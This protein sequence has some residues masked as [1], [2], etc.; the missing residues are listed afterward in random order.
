[1]AMVLCVG[2]DDVLMT[3][4]KMILER[5]GHT[6]ISVTDQDALF[7]ACHDHAVKVAVLGQ[8]MEPRSK[9]LAFSMIRNHCPGAKVLSL[10][11]AGSGPILPEADDWLAVP[12]D[13]PSDLAE[14]V[15]KLAR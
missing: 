10:H 13:V 11:R 5:A 15:D 3:T 4:R 8:N 6:V 7:S 2:T 14:H 9:R 12:A 1:M